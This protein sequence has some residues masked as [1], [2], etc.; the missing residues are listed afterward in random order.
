M[1]KVRERRLKYDS[2]VLSLNESAKLVP[3]KE[4]GKSRGK[5]KNQTKFYILSWR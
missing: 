4:M 3:S 1:L 5:K 2:M